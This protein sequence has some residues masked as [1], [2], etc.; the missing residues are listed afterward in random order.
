MKR[1]SILCVLHLSP[2]NHFNSHLMEFSFDFDTFPVSLSQL[3]YQQIHFYQ[4]IIHSL[5]CPIA[6]SIVLFNFSHYF[7]IHFPSIHCVHLVDAFLPL[8]F[9]FTSRILLYF[10]HFL[11]LFLLFISTNCTNFHT[12]LKCYLLARSV[13]VVVFGIIFHLSGSFLNAHALWTIIN[14]ILSPQIYAFICNLF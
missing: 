8:H 14:H 6:G 9:R 12:Y 11:L 2:A 7:F 13:V 3:S 10:A 4:H 1:V 5:N